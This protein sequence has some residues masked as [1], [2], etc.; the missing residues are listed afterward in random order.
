MSTVV[1]KV[2]VRFEKTDPIPAELDRRGAAGLA[3]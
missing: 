2:A 3:C 1:H